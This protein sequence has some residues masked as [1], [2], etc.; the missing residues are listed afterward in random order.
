MRVCFWAQIVM[1]YGYIRMVIRKSTEMVI[2][3]AVLLA[4][5]PAVVRFVGVRRRS[6]VRV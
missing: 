3:G 6:Q 4:G 5:L 2:K 1:R